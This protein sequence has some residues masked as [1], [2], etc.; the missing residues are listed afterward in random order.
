MAVEWVAIAAAIAPHI[1]KFAAERAEKLAAKSA[2]GVLAKL[3][4]RVLPDEK[5]VRANEA[6]LS[7]FGK[8]LESWI[9]LDTLLAEPYRE[10]LKRFLKNPSVQDSLMAPLDGK[11]ELDSAL[12]R[13]I[14]NESHLIELPTGFAW[15][16][17]STTYGQSIQRQML[18]NPA[19]R[20]VVAALAEIR[21]AE[22]NERS[23]DALD[24]IVG[25]ARRFRSDAI[26]S[27][28]Q[29]RLRPPETRLARYGL[30][31]LRT[32][33]APRERLR[34][35]IGE[36]GTSTSRPHARLPARAE[37]GGKNSRRAS[38]PRRSKSVSGRSTRNLAAARSWK[39]WTTRHISAWSSSG[40]RDLASQ[41]C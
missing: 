17:V 9:E 37:R 15:E 4:R 6:F 41:P 19:L 1:K 30:G 8:E 28:N 25:P 20:P 27:S 13:G 40:I 7:R 21:S 29:D 16:K 33:C 34:S 14:W 24:R 31:A 26:H 38:L 10:A 35:A 12:L 11:S 5:A 39:W 36:A 22:A 32:T 18:A 2:D 23:A 3:Y